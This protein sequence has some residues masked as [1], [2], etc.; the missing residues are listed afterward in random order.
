MTL[1]CS[2]P[3]SNKTYGPG[4]FVSEATVIA[5]KDE[6]GQLQSFL[7]R[8]FDSAIRLTVDIGRE[9][10]PEILIAGDFKRNTD[11][12]EIIGWGGA[13]VVQEALSRLG[14][15][16][17]LVEGNT[18]P[19]DVIESLV[20]KPFYR[21]SYISGVKDG[22]KLRYSDWNQIAALEEGAESLASRF[23]RSLTKGYPRN[24]HPDIM[25]ERQASPVAA[26]TADDDPF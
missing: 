17:D 12:N 14:Y 22:G 1:S 6:S 16:G 26:A 5:A 13:F 25:D 9:F 21:L 24:Y 7:N 2:K 3:W 15:T 20:G 23:K 8:T 10:F 4:I 18:I 11:T 19:P